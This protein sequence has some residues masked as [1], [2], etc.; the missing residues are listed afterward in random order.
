MISQSLKDG[1][2][3]MVQLAILTGLSVMSL[4]SPHGV[5]RPRH[6]L[7]ENPYDPYAICVLHVGTHFQVHVRRTA[8]SFNGSVALT[9]PYQECPGRYDQ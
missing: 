4:G 7:P 5:F 2:L 3:P 8:Y 9:Y 6:E 1:M